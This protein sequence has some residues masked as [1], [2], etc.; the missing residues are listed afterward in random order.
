M[1]IS[2]L[3]NKTSDYETSDSVPYFGNFNMNTSSSKD[4]TSYETFDYIVR[5]YTDDE[6]GP[7]IDIDIIIT[8]SIVWYSV[9][10]VLGLIGNGLVIWIAGFKMKTVSSVWFLHLAIADFIKCISLPLRIS[11]WALFAHISYDHDLCTIGITLIYINMS[12]SIYFMSIIGIDR[13]VSILWP[14]WTKIHRTPRNTRIISILTWLLSLLT[15]IPYIMFNHF[16]EEVSECFPKNWYDNDDKDKIKTRKTMFI[17]KNICMF[18]FPFTIILISYTLV[19]LKIIKVRKA[20]RSRR[21]FRLIVAVVVCFFICWFPYSTWPF[22]TLSGYY[23]NLDRLIEEIFVCLAYFSSCINPIIYVFF[24]H[25][26]KKNFI[27]SLPATLNKAFNEDSELGC[28][29]EATTHTNANLQTS[30]L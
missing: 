13:C 19:C 9:I 1:N 26:F 8:M 27:K 18:A 29:E 17:I 21:P 23:W 15:S 30:L 6:D 4:E 5:N 20:N 28:R 3:G 22:I 25:D 14:I 16:Y 7:Y 10:L 12:T 2:F 24:C 11:E